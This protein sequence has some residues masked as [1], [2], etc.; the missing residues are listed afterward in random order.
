MEYKNGI[1]ATWRYWAWKRIRE[2]IKVH[3]R[4]ATVL[5]L[6]G[7]QPEDLVAAE[8]NGFRIENIVAVDI[9]KKA[10][11]EA[12]KAGCVAIQG[13]I[14]DVA[15]LWDDGDI[16]ACVADYC[17]GLTFEQYQRSFNLFACVNGP[18]V[19]NFQRGRE[20]SESTSIMREMFNSI[21]HSKHRGEQFV[22][23][24]RQ[25]IAF[26][27]WLQRNGFSPDDALNVTAREQLT[28]TSEMEKREIM[29]LSQNFVSSCKPEFY[30]YVSNRVVMDTVILSNPLQVQRQG[31]KERR[32][33]KLFTKLE[34]T[35][36]T[37]NSLHRKLVKTKRT[38]V[39]KLTA[40][41]AV[42]TMAG[43]VRLDHGQIM[44]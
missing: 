40:L 36:P 33:L 10:V 35:R 8:K 21:Q 3:P 44:Q 13:D 6:A 11:E 15:S 29:E 30:S 26:S 16:H 41:K 34:E 32:M 19:F 27:G 25:D 23:M 43:A 12:R 24:M 42:R 38:T 7:P 5:F 2:K 28:A 1:K 31:E 22:Y 14:H 20:C 18:S 9:D 17:Y 37:E 4:F 39:S